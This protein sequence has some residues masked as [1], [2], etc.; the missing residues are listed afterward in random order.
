M[1]LENHVW[2]CVH[3]NKWLR[4][5]RSLV[6]KLIPLAFPLFGVGLINIRILFLKV[7][8]LSTYQTLWSRHFHLITAERKK[9]FLKKLCFVL[10][11]GMFSVFLVEGTL[12]LAHSKAFLLKYLLL[13]L[14][15]LRMRYIGQI[16]FSG[17]WM[18]CELFHI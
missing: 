10:K 7:L 3:A 15:L 1:Y 18:S 14:W 8:K 6:I 17:E 5:T 4:S 9:D 13:H 11:R 2:I 16:L 12:D